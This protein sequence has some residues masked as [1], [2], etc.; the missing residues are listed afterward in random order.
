M[1][2]SITED[3]TMRRTRFEG[4]ATVVL[5]DAITKLPARRP[6]DYCPV[7]GFFV[8]PALSL[9]LKWPGVNQNGEPQLNPKEKRLLVLAEEFLGVLDKADQN[10]D[11]RPRQTNE[12]HD[13]QHAHC[14]DGELHT[15][16]VARIELR[17]AFQ[18]L[19]V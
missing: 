14:D 15:E 10:H 9:L 2:V 3:A 6:A 17:A 19:I 12:K 16:I 13:F 11:S 8:R 18:T 7:S 5:E 1:K 4:G